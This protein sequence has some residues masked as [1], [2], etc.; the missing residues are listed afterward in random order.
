MRKSVSLRHCF[1][2][3]RIHDANAVVH[4]MA[5]KI[6]VRSHDARCGTT[7]TV[8]RITGRV[9]TRAYSKLGEGSV[10]QWISVALSV[11]TLTVPTIRHAVSV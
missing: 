1:D 3:T 8:G 11:F 5:N 9:D 10:R 4:V 6:E 7:F 2:I